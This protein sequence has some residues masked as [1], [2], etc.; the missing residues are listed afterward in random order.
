MK[1]TQTQV[2]ELRGQLLAVKAELR[3]TMADLAKECG[4]PR[5]TLLEFLTPR[6]PSE[7]TLKALQRGLAKC[8]R[9]RVR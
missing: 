4:I 5:T 3:L 9:R 1:L 8:Q 6:T 2:A 7:T